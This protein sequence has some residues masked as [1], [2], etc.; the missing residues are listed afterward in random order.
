MTTK[1]KEMTNRKKTL[2]T[3][4]DSVV[5]AFAGLPEE[6]TE[7]RNAYIAELRSLGWTLQSLAAAVGVTR[8]RVRQIVEM[9]TDEDR[10]ETLF[11]GLPLPLPPE[12][13]VRSRP[14]YVE[15]TA[16]TLARLLELQ[17]IA[18][19]VRANSDNFRE[20]AE[21]YTALINKAHVDEGVPLYRLALRLGVT[22]G[23]LRFRLVRYG[24]KKPVA[25][26]TS[27]AYTPVKTENRTSTTV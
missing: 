6:D 11:A 8:E 7:T 12:K 15:P 4:P 10:D 26:G 17:P 13:P 9:R 27:K 20:E 24:Y 14:V 1:S 18:Q 5:G 19:Q 3:L 2:L 25:G 21:E 22:H 16:A 23:A